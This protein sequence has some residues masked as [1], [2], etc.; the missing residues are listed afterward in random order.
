MGYL[1]LCAVFHVAFALGARFA[2]ARKLDFFLVST[3]NYGV[4]TVGA[5]VAGIWQPWWRVDASAILLGGVQGV[6]YGLSMGGVYILLRSRGVGVGFVLVRTSVVIPTVLSIVAFGEHPTITALVGMALLFI[7]VP[8]LISR[9]LRT[10][11]QISRLWQWILIGSVVLLPGIAFA[12]VKTFNEISHPQLQG[13]FI[14]STFSA[15]VMAG[16]VMLILRRRLQPDAPSLRGFLLWWRPLRKASR[17]LTLATGAV[18][19]ISNVA[20][21]SSLVRALEEIPGTIAF[22]VLTV[23]A[24]VLTTAAGH[25]FWGER[26]GYMALLG[27]AVAVSGLILVNL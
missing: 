11:S 18:M 24:V 12:S 17:Y 13:V 23:L 9:N 19:G 6:C 7:S 2:Q 5:L 1:T 14:L 10:G 20:Q 8:L 27:L 3:I 25:I 4:A 21:V 16:L 22:P 26:H 15:A